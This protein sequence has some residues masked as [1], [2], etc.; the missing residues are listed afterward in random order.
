VLDFDA[1]GNKLQ[2][3]AATSTADSAGGVDAFDEQSYTEEGSAAWDPHSP[4]LCAV[5][6]GC[7]LKLVDT[8]EMEVTSQQ[9]N[10]HDET[11]R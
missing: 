9:L 1:G 5:T 6:I 11:I 7:A 3:A 10:A 2:P 4:K 8:R